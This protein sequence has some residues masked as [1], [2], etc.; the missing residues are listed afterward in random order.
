MGSKGSPKWFTRTPAFLIC[1]VILVGMVLYL[2]WGR[3]NLT[4]SNQVL[5]SS[6]RDQQARSS[7]EITQLRLNYKTNT[8]VPSAE[9]LELLRLRAEVSRLHQLTNPLPVSHEQ[10][11]PISPKKSEKST[12]R[13]LEEHLGPLTT[14][15]DS[16]ALLALQIK[17]KAFEQ[18]VLAMRDFLGDHQNTLPSSLDAILEALPEDIGTA[19]IRLNMTFLQREKILPTKT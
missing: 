3:R 9:K 17:E 10:S 11:F 16:K 14:I 1:F 4:R 12:S 2:S 7:E 13:R 15:E 5:Q 8:S 18:F 6:L 19:L